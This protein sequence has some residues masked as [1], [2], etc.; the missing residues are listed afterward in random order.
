MWRLNI[1][2]PPHP[3]TFLEIDFLP[4]GDSMFNSCRAGEVRV[5]GISGMPM[6]K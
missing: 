4:F 5:G 6:D 3:E 2:S 1:T